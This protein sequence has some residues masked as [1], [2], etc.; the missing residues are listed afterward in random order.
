MTTRDLAATR[1]RTFRAEP[2]PSGRPDDPG[3]LAGIVRR[4]A[5][6]ERERLETAELDAVDGLVG[7]SWR[8]RGSSRTVD[9]AAD[10]AAQLT[11]MSVRV[12]EA[13]E[14]DASRWALAGDQLLVDL[15]LAW[16]ALPAGTR[17]TIG[18]AE[19]EVTDEP[20]TGCAKFSARFGSDALRW[21]N[22]PDG[23]PARRR[24]MNTRIVRSGVIRVG[25]AI[26]R[27]DPSR[28]VED[29][30]NVQPARPR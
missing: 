17:L 19:I 22:E 13:I 14:P 30:P 3:R 12:L 9:G 16:D 7:D 20:H 5:V 21:I 28:P 23:R 25:D 6:D 29:R 24:G 4:P 8:A 10:P 26:V 2:G 15:D 11:L 18:T 27:V 1:V